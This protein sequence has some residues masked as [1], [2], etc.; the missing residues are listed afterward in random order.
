M[1]R[2]QHVNF[3]RERHH[4]S[5]S[6]NIYLYA[7]SKERRKEVETKEVALAEMDKGIHGVEQRH[8]EKVKEAVKEAETMVCQLLHKTQ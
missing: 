4:A 6:C 3:V 5:A 8:E 2:V 7:C 1:A